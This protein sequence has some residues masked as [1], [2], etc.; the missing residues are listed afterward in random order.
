MPIK[1]SRYAGTIWVRSIR[2]EKRNLGEDTVG[3]YGIVADT[4]KMLT[5]RTLRMA[6][7]VLLLIGGLCLARAH[8]KRHIDLGFRT[9]K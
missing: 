8:R 5:G 3:D 6:F 1:T 9:A 2:Q 7:L 4:E